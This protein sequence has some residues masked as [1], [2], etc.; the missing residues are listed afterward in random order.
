MVRIDGFNGYNYDNY[1]YIP[2]IKRIENHCQN[3]H[4]K[5]ILLD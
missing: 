3:L 5:F 1:Y 2:K 4:K